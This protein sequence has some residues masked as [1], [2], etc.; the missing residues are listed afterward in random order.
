[1]TCIVGIVDKE[2]NRVV[3]GADSCGSN[4]RLQSIRKDTK[5]F[6]VGEFLIGCTSSFRMIQLLRFSLRL[7]DVGG[8]DIY[9]YMC[10][11]F[12]SSVREC[13]RIGGFIK[14]EDKVEI[15]G[16][17]LVGYKERL[18]RVQD[19][20]QVAEKLDGLDACGIGEEVVSGAIYALNA[21]DNFSPEIKIKIAL[22]ASEY[23]NVGVCAPFYIEST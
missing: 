11:D 6:R 18:F 19:D 7:P 3:I 2:N 5:L 15:G 22:E 14:E 23:N 17:F 8:K 4:G 9:E 20:F 13:F 21:I 12:I 1:M 16:F 10:T